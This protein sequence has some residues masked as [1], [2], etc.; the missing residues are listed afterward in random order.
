LA[1]VLLALLAPTGVQAQAARR[2]LAAGG[3]SAVDECA[4]YAGS[5]AIAGWLNGHQTCLD[6]DCTDLDLSGCTSSFS[7][8]AVPIPSEIGLLTKLN[9]LD[10]TGVQLSGPIP[11]EIGLL[12]GQGAMTIDFRQTAFPSGPGFNGP[13]PTE[14]GNVYMLKNFYAT[15][16]SLTGTLPTELGKLTQLLQDFYVDNNALTGTVPSELG[17]CTHLQWVECQDNQL[18]GCLPIELNNWIS[19]PPNWNGVGEVKEARFSNNAGLCGY[20]P[21]KIAPQVTRGAQVGSG[22]NWADDGLTGN[23]LGSECANGGCGTTDRYVVGTSTF[24]PTSSTTDS[25][26][27]TPTVAPT[28]PVSA[29]PTTS[30]PVSASPTGRDVFDLQQRLPGC[31]S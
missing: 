10:L 17:Q 5:P 7:G 26:T 29:S 21:E 6:D 24:N 30:L 12:G 16:T 14:I 9:K 25:P 23:Q 15:G 13:I 11:T 4:E 19:G 31:Q 18:T 20:I 3:P 27:G 28:P 8:A 2:V 1:L 22:N